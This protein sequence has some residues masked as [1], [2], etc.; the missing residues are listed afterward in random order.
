MDTA[1]G[2]GF[3]VGGSG[4]GMISGDS[5][6]RCTDRPEVQAYLHQITMR[7]LDRWKLPP[8]IPPNERVTL[9]FRIDVAGSASAVDAM[10]A[11]SPFPSMPEAARCLARLPITAKFRNPL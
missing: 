2:E 4:S 9:R 10:R 3:L 5:G 6:G 11:A 8:G 7:T 1:V